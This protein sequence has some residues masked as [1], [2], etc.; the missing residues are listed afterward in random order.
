MR[1]S[2]E[3]RLGAAVL[4]GDVVI[5]IDNCEHELQSVFLCQALTQQKLNIRVLG[6]S[7]NVETPVTATMFATGNNL[8]IAGDLTRRALLGALDARCEHPERRCYGSAAPTPA[9][10]R[11]GC[12]KTT[13]AGTCSP[14]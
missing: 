13:R 4:A 12:R 1:R 5:S 7:R 11:S 8:T 3:K 9:T 6:S 10:P 2:F 14:P